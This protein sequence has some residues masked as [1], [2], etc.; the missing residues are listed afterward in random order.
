MLLSK[1]SGD[2]VLDKMELI[3]IWSNVNGAEFVP[4]LNF[5]FPW[6]IK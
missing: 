2:I 5:A 6:Q 4:E 1:A 3:E